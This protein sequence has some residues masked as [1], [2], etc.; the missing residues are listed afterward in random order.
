M[1][2]LC[3]ELALLEH[4]RLIDVGEAGAIVDEYVSDVHTDRVPDGEFGV[5]WG[6]GEGRVERI[7]LLDDSSRPVSTVRTGDT[8]TFRFHYTID[9]PLEK[10]VF[11]LALYTI[12]G[13]HVTG[14]NTRNSGIVPDKLQG[15][16][17]VD[18]V[19]DRLLLVRGVYDLSVSLADN[20]LMHVYDFRHRAFRFD[21]ELGEP[22]EEFGVVSMGG[23]WNCLPVQVGPS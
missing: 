17:Y 22:A 13:M 16:G 5:R 3:D 20:A 18:F 1:R 6:S 21:V 19:I 12:D 2:T 9:E 14:P 8:V 23:R 7:E 4:G 10:P 15:S 11:G